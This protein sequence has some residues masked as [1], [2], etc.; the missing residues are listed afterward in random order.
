MGSH[1]GAA[2]VKCDL[3][4][5]DVAQGMEEEPSILEFPLLTLDSSYGT[6]SRT[7]KAFEVHK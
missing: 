6:W 1:I 5:Q 4:C 7:S 3:I 2:L